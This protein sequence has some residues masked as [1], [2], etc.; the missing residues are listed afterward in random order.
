M[1]VTRLHDGSLLFLG[2]TLGATSESL[3]TGYVY[4]PKP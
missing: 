3:A 1:S 2:G 4:T